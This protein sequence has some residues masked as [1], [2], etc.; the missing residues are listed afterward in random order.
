MMCQNGFCTNCMPNY[1]KQSLINLSKRD[2]VLRI[3]YICSDSI[4][5]DTL[6]INKTKKSAQC[7]TA[8][9]VGTV[10]LCHLQL[11]LTIP[12][13]TNVLPA[14]VKAFTPTATLLRRIQRLCLLPCIPETQLAQLTS[15][16]AVL[17]WSRVC[18]R[19]LSRPRRVGCAANHL[20]RHVYS[21]SARSQRCKL[22]VETNII[23]CIVHSLTDS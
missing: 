12:S 13:Q 6:N 22:K 1:T 7:L 2:V 19:S 14:L 23:A 9:M 8:S 5:E 4:C 10:F 17:Q 16:Q 20:I 3:A 15:V 11:V 18:Y 21:F